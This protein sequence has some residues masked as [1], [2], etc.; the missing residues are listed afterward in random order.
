MDQ[1]DGI[2]DYFIFNC[3]T[4]VFFCMNSTTNKLHECLDI[5]NGWHIRDISYIVQK[6]EK[7]V[8][9]SG[10]ILVKGLRYKTRKY[11]NAAEPNNTNNKI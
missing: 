2:M 4:A 8:Y 1:R 3:S 6:K 9:S 11:Q 5:A 7:W 10:N